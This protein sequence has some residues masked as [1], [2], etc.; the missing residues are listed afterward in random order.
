MNGSQE[1]RLD[2]Y[3]KMDARR[4]AIERGESPDQSRHTG[5]SPVDP[6]AF[7]QKKRLF[8]SRSDRKF[9]GVCGGL[10][11]YFGVDPTIV[12]IVFVLG[13]VFGWG[14]FLIIYLVLAGVLQDEPVHFNHTRFE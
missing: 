8:K 10:A 2:A 13:V 3:L 5:T 6:Y 9:M 12:R 11:S 7:E 1:D 14:S 4:R